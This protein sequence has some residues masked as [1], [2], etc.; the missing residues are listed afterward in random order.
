MDCKISVIIPVYNTER[1][2]GVCVDSVISQ[3]F[4]EYEIICINDGSQDNSLEILRGYEKIHPKVHIISYEENQGL[5]HARNIGL[6]AAKGKYVYFLDSD[7]WMAEGALRHLYSLATEKDTDCLLFC[8]ELEMET[9]GIGS[10]TLEF[11][12]PQYEGQI[13]TGEEAFRIMIDHGKYTSSAWRQFWRRQFLL[14]NDC[15]YVEGALAEDTLFS[16]RAYLLAGRV[17]ITNGKYHVFRRHGGTLSTLV[18]PEKC[19]WIFRAYCGMLQ[20]WM[21]GDY[22]EETSKAIAKWIDAKYRQLKRLYFRNKGLVEELLESECERYLFNM[23]VRQN[24]IISMTV[25]PEKIEEIK[26]FQ[27]IVIY[28]AD[29]YAMDV[30][31]ALQNNNV[32]VLCYVV[33]ELHSNA[34]GTANIPVCSIKELNVNPDECMIVLGVNKKN[35]EDVIETMKKYHFKNYM[36][37]D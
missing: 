29:G 9:P 26:K 32:E 3:D 4:D 34:V 17:V 30:T 5:A 21:N 13:L 23:L 36:A 12:L 10:P 25:A 35:R 6:K 15:F 24:K 31:E 2:V 11:D 33:T 28:G 27:N 8:S 22:T 1:Y 18:S 16:F 14:G 19:L 7:D 20:I 37:L